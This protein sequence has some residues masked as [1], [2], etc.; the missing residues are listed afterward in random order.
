MLCNPKSEVKTLNKEEFG[1]A[2][3]DA[4][5]KALQFIIDGFKNMDFKSFFDEFVKLIKSVL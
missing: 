5:S 2:V 3:G 4:F 1:K